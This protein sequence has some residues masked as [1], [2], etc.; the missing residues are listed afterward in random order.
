[1]ASVAGTIHVAS[2]AARHRGLA[3]V[4]LAVAAAVI[5]V[6]SA[7]AERAGDLTAEA[8]RIVGAPDRSAASL[9]EAIILYERAVRLEATNAA[10]RIKLA[11]AALELGDVSADGLAWYELGQTAAERAVELNEGDA[12]GHFLLAANRGHVARRRSIFQV[13]PSIVGDLE[14]HLRRALTL[15]PR[16]ARTLH[17]MGVLLRDTPLI[18]R[19]YL[20]GKRSEVERYLVAA[21]EADPRFPQARL[22]LAEFYRGTGR[23]ALARPQAQAVLD[24]T[25]SSGDRLWRE[26]YRSEAAALLESLSAK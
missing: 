9:R 7:L 13:G 2:A 1:M 5:P 21:V 10:I 6:G 11:E 8:D 16:H 25:S 4:W 3:I 19:F 22:D 12:H 20:K 23:A 17:M 24:M 18:A 15:N 26:K 14:Q